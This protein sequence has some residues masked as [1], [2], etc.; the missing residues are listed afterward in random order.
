MAGYLPW[1]KEQWAKEGWGEL[2]NPLRDRVNQYRTIA[3]EALAEDNQHPRIPQMVAFLY[4]GLEMGLRF[5]NE[6]GVLSPD[7]K[8]ITLNDGWDYLIA[9]AREQNQRIQKESACKRFLEALGS[10]INS[11]Q[12]WATGKSD[13]NEPAVIPGRRF[14]GW[15]DEE[16]YYLIPS[17]VYA[18][19][20]EL[21]QRTGE[22]F[23]VKDDAV[24]DQLKEQQYTVTRSSDKGGTTPEYITCKG[25]AIRV[26]KLKKQALAEP[27]DED[28]DHVITSLL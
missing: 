4:A 5:A 17:T 23:T 1:L 11:G 22:I 27:G 14:I 6:I 19:V 13:V 20:C 25:T 18:M 28:K 15:Q 21:C 2:N 16:Y 10:L 3:Y 24:W 9:L 26:L 7:L 8:Q 12:A